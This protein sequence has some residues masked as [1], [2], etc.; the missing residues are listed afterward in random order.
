MCFK[1]SAVLFEVRVGIM[2]VT[3]YTNYYME[4]IEPK[5]NFIKTLGIALGIVVA[6]LGAIRYVK[7]DIDTKF[8]AVQQAQVEIQAKEISLSDL[9]KL[10]SDAE[11]ARRYTPQLDHLITTKDQLLAFS[12]DIGFVAKQA[13]FSGAPQFKEEGAP[14]TADLQKTSFSLLIEGQKNF[15]DLANFFKLVEQSKYFVHFTSLDV[16]H[17]GNTV[18]VGSDGYVLSF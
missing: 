12:T 1:H 5:K 3:Q 9:A 15:G 4:Y 18:R 7:S 13:G 17:E 11:K 16:S 2:L 10:Q 14:S 8:L 6:L